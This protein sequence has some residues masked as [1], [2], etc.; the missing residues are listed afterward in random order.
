MKEFVKKVPI[1]GPAAVSLCRKWVKPSKPF[2]GSAEYW[3]ARYAAGGNSGAGSYDRLADFKANMIN[4]FVGENRVETVIE[5][6]C[7]DGNQL[8]LA[9]YPAYVGFDVSENA[10]SRCKELFSKDATKR[11]EVLRNYAGETAQ[12]TLSLDV[13]YHLT[14]DSTFVDYMNRLF[15]SSVRYVVVYSS[16]TDSQRPDQASHVRHRKFTDW[17]GKNRPDWKL[18]EHVPNQY[19]LVDD[20]RKGSFADFYI[21]EKA[22]GN[23]QAGH[24]G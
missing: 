15:D 21:Y 3:N 12:L 18:K 8:T 11:F 1:L 7:G 22:R 4:Q 19:P 14:E 23:Q 9:Q 2:A 24:L 5:Y 20:E 6:G 13:I 16:D 10:V 17:I